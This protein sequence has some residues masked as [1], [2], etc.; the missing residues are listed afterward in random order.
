MNDLTILIGYRYYVSQISKWIQLVN[1]NHE[2][3]WSGNYQWKQD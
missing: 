1:N 2:T 3:L